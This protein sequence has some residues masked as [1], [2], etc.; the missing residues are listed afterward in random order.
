MYT[1]TAARN[2]DLTIGKRKDK[3]ESDQFYDWQRESD[4]KWFFESRVD[5]PQNHDEAGLN[6]WSGE[7]WASSSGNYARISRACA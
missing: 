4:T 2:S 5:L 6:G 1:L 7:A 3:T